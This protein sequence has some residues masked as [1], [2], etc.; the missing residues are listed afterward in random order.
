[1]LVGYI[2]AIINLTHHR[3]ETQMTAPPA[4]LLAVVAET[5]NPELLL[6]PQQSPQVALAFAFW[7][8]GCCMLTQ[9]IGASTPLR[10]PQ[11]SSQT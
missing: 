1:M 10:H 6:I 5:D 9:S 4:G 2:L 3:S 8:P 7:T 11:H